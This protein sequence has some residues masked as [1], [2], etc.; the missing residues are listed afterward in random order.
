MPERGALQLLEP[1]PPAV[2]QAEPQRALVQVGEA[3]AL[4]AALR[5]KCGWNTADWWTQLLQLLKPGDGAAAQQK[6]RRL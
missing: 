4:D 6:R 1:M 5:G 2:D 3:M